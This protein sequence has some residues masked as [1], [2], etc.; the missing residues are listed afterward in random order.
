MLDE[1]TSLALQTTLQ[2]E[3]LSE[4]LDSEKLASTTLKDELES[5]V[6]AS[7]V[8]QHEL[9]SVVEAQAALHHELVKE[10]EAKVHVFSFMRSI[11]KLNLFLTFKHSRFH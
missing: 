2:L 9:E 1:A 6:E 11:S 8:L 3:T 5:I 4:E 7:T 10:R